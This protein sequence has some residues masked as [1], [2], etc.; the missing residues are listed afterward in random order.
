MGRAGV[1]SG[2]TQGEERKEGHK[3]S[4][5]L[6]TGPQQAAEGEDGGPEEAPCE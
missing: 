3:Q 4:G 5:W 6:S 1:R 2:L